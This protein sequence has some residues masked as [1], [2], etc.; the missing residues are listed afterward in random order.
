MSGIVV[1]KSSL[2]VVL[3]SA[4]A[5]EKK[6]AAG[7]TVALSSFDNFMPPIPVT[8]LLAFEHPIHDPVGTIKTALSQALAHYRPIA[9]RLDGHGGIVCTG[10]G[11]TFVGAS[12]SCTLAEAMA[13]L[14]LH[15]LDLAV[16]Y[17]GLLCRDADPLLLAQVTEF[18][19]GGFVV[20]ATGT[21]SWPTARG[22]R[23]SCRP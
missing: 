7:G 6:Q 1:T 19:C 2:L 22:W 5:L 14:P 3:P 11:V 12:A 20:A 16:R 21:T 23:S 13:A 18:S 8:S 10:E 4:T 15:Q 17:P 9:G